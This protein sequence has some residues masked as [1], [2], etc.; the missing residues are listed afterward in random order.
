[1]PINLMTISRLY[2]RRLSPGEARAL[3]AAEAAREGIGEPASLPPRSPNRGPPY[4]KSIV[5]RK[6]ALG[7]DAAE[8]DMRI[9]EGV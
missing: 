2:G 7:T 5:L 6:K 9:V 8:R 1:M 3:V 4:W